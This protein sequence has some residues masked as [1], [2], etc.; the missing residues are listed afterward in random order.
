M[1]PDVIQQKIFL[2]FHPRYIYSKI[3]LICHWWKHLVYKKDFLTDISHTYLKITVS[4]PITYKTLVP[5]L[6]QLRIILFFYFFI[7]FYFVLCLGSVSVAALRLC[8]LYVYNLV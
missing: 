1:L 5:H 8:N 6:Q 3:P 4:T 7:L 2:F